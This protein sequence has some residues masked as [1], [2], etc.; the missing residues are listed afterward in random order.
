MRAPDAS[1]VA[2]LT[3]QDGL[4]NDCD[5][6]SDC[7]DTDCAEDD[8]RSSAA[9]P[10]VSEWGIVVMSLLTLTVGTLI[11]TRRSPATT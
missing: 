3:C 5:G 11:H 7:D 2:N 8:A 6:A 10:T 4:D 9:I 1:E